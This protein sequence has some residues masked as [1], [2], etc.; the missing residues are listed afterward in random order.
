MENN[1]IISVIIVNYNVRDFLE[2][3]LISIRRA[4]EDI[5]SQIIVVDNNSID[6]SVAM[7]HE[8]FPEVTCIVSPQNRG[9]SAANNL[10]IEQAKGQY[11]VLINPDTVVQEDTFKV[12]L[13]FF[14]RTPDAAAATC[15]ILNPDGSFSVDCRHSIPTPATAF[16]KLLGLNRLFPKSKI[17]GRYNL[18]YLDENKC[19][20]V[21]GIS[22]SFMMIKA[23]VV[24]AVGPL[25]EQFFMYCEDIDYCHRIN[26]NGGKI[27]Y[28]PDTQIIHYKGESTK[29]NN[30]DYVI[31]FNRSLYLFYKKHYQ[32]N[33]IAPFKWLILLG[34]IFRGIVVYIRNLISKYYPVLIDLL[35]LNGVLFISFWL[36]F[37]YKDGFY[38]HDFFHRYVVVN[39][40]TSVLYFFNALFL[41]VHDR[42]RLSAPKAIR[43]LFSTFLAVAAII[44]F[45]NQFAF[46]RFVVIVSAI[47]SSLGMIG[48]RVLFRR[49]ARRYAPALEKDFLRRNVLIVG[50]DAQ[51]A[52]LLEKLNPHQ[53]S[54]L[55][56]KGVVGHNRDRIGA[57]IGGFPIV[58]ALDQLVEYTRLQHIDVIIF[59]THNIS[60]QYVFALMT[61]LNPLNVEVKM[62]P[63]HLEF[64]VGK[65]SIEKLDNLPLVDIDYAYGKLYNRVIKRGFDLLL[66]LF[67][68]LLNSPAYLI[69]FLLKKYP[70]K[71]VHK[72]H[73]PGKWLLVTPVGKYRQFLTNILNV[74]LNKMSFI[75]ACLDEQQ[76]FCSSLHYKPGLTGIVQQNPEQFD[77]PVT[78]EALERQ[79]LKNQN[80]ALDI[81]LLLKSLH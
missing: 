55:N 20:P 71:I 58:A 32:N 65:T 13:D 7:L 9:F 22:G 67:I 59:S 60:Y 44:F 46:S 3:A 80:L 73:L 14:S 42:D 66:A 39:I 31:T 6:D 57:R 25:D 53:L 40:I 1:P 51:T 56:I 49:F 81:Q 63:G 68:F 21:E 79:Y 37:S 50:D 48:W 5:P 34:V 4:L 77:D 30:L 41:N 43:V 78:A 28:V 27:Y 75:G 17:F 69:L 76:N 70:L 2:Q 12:L 38:L 47:I 36:R 19:Y 54:G 62:V 26:L 24:R 18:T 10:G 16:W 52:D 33:Y 11:L 61:E 64:M 8:R 45:F 15:K 23:D 74:L 29:K 35:L 72:K